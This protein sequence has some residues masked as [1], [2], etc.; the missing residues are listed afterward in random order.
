MFRSICS[1]NS[2]LL[3]VSFS[4]SALC[5]MPNAAFFT[6][7]A[8]R[9][10]PLLLCFKP[11]IILSPSSFCASWPFTVLFKCLLCPLSTN[12]SSLH[13]LLSSTQADKEV[14]LTNAI[15]R[16]LSQPLT[17]IRQR[18][19]PFYKKQAWSVRW[20]KM[21]LFLTM[22][23]DPV[24]PVG[25]AFCHTTLCRFRHQPPQIDHPTMWHW[26]HFPNSNEWEGLHFFTQSESLS[27]HR[28]S[29]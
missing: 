10:H 25:G 23:Y 16:R 4:T 11:P 24:G 8:L 7:S 13:H 15:I 21:W 18:S 22:K 29:L 20:A 19:P 9:L 3:G 1:S 26:A 12:L 6:S 17:L 27:E 14:S 2:P 5:K 28:L